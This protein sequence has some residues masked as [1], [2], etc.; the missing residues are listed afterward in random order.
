MITLV[1][2]GTR[3]GKSKV[4]ETLT[5]RSPGPVTYVA[6]TTV[7]PADIEMRRRIAAHRARRPSAW[8]TLE[9]PPA[10]LSSVLAMTAGTVLV[11]SLGAWVASATDFAVDLGRLGEALAARKGDRVLVSD[12]V[13]LGVHPSSEVGRRFRDVLGEVNQA[14]AAIADEVLLVVAGRVVPLVDLSSR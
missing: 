1:L 14:V 12:E 7:D 13:G 10:D 5:G 9:V 8:V 4:A 6:T 3:S 2:G 11:D